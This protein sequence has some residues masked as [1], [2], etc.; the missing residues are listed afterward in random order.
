MSENPK[1][2]WVILSEF[3]VGEWNITG[4]RHTELGEMACVNS[5]RH[6]VEKLFELVD[7]R[8][9]PRIARF[10]EVPIET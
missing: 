10:V 5:K 8:N 1:E 9:N 6:V 3:K 4:L 2:L 7:K